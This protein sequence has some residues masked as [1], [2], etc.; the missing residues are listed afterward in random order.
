MKVFI[1]FVTLLLV[2]CSQQKS[3]DREAGEEGEVSPQVAEEGMEVVDTETPEDRS[4]VWNMDRRK[5]IKK[6]R[7]H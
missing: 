4:L 1:L 2:Q 3:L 5:K 6:R 7:H